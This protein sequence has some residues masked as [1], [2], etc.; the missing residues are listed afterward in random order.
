RVRTNKGSAADDGRI[1]RYRNTRIGRRGR[2]RIVPQCAGPA[3]VSDCLLLLRN[4]QTA[5]I[6]GRISGIGAEVEPRNAAGAAQTD[7]PRHVAE[8]ECR[9][10][11]ARRSAG[12]PRLKIDSVQEVAEFIDTDRQISAYQ[13]VIGW[14]GVGTGVAQT[15]APGADAVPGHARGGGIGRGWGLGKLSGIDQIETHAVGAVAAGTTRVAAVSHGLE[16]DLHA[17]TGIEYRTGDDRAVLGVAVRSAV[18][19]AQGALAGWIGQ[20]HR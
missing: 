17:L 14:V 1:V 18:G 15:T 11:A 20:C 12:K 6:I 13:T 2:I 7:A 5:R 10:V 16:R 19:E 9:V 3:G 8:T 4:S